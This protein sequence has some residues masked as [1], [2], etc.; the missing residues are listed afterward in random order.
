[1]AIFKLT[2]FPDV[3]TLQRKMAGCLEQE[4]TRPGSDPFAVMLSGGKTPLAIY[5]MLAE[6]GLKASPA[7]HVFFSDERDVPVLSDENNYHHTVALLKALAIPDSRVM[8]V[9]TG[10]PPA[11]AAVQYH[12]ELRR[13]LGAGGRMTLGILGIGQDGHTASLFST[14]DVECGH[15]RYAV[16]ISHDPKPDR[17]SVTPGLLARVEKLVI[18]A[19]GPEKRDIVTKLL[20]QP[21]DVVAGLAL[22]NIALV[23]VWQA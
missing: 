13:F 4:L 7:A 19:T 23:E 2:S 20:N 17:I 12:H 9:R 10:Q 21:D 6:K 22:R 3:V 8:R 14:S 16:A 15:G 11:E 5:S 18:L 1:M